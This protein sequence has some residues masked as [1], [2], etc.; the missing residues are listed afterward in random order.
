MWRTRDGRVH[1]MAL[2][3]PREPFS[4]AAQEIID[5]LVGTP[6]GERMLERLDDL[7]ETL[8]DDLAAT[9]FLPADEDAFVEESPPVGLVNVSIRTPTG[10][11]DAV[12]ST[13]LRWRLDVL[14]CLEELLDPSNR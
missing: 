13:P 2:P 3:N 11:W 12:R 9:P 14:D 10:L 4:R 6:D 7:R 1:T 5:V 8:Y